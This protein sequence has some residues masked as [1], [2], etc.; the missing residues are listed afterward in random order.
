MTN[1]APRAEHFIA[2]YEHS[3]DALHALVASVAAAPNWQ[4]KYRQLMQAG[5]LLPA[6]GQIWQTEDARVRGCESAAWLWHYHQEGKHYFLAD[7]D[8]RIVKG[9]TALL[10]AA[11]NG[12]SGSEI[13]Q[14]DAI[15]YFDSLGLGNQLSPSRTNGLYALVQ[16]MQTLAKETQ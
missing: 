15:Q 5:R 13:A 10:L 12:H 11:L 6:F 16:R 3:L 1:V 9:L 7:S 4:E 2:G 14:F 8:A